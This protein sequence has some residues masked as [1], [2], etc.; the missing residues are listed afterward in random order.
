MEKRH[1][2]RAGCSLFAGQEC[3]ISHQI[4]PACSWVKLARPYHAEK[5]IRQVHVWVC[6]HSQLVEGGGLLVHVVNGQSCDI[7]QRSTTQAQV[8][9]FPFRYLLQLRNKI[10]QQYDVI[11]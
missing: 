10:Y 1:V 11:T 3:W 2:N 5:H 7:L 4:R 6:A 9:I 8:L